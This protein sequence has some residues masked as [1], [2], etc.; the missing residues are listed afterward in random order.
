MT[1]IRI[2]GLSVFPQVGE[3]PK[4]AR[5]VGATL[6]SATVQRVICFCLGPEGTN[7]AQ[8]AR[9]WLKRMSV[10]AKSEVRLYDTPEECLTQ[11]RLITDPGVL[12][13]F[14]TCAVYSRESQFFFGNPDVLPF[15]FQE[16]MFLDE[17]QLATTGKNAAELK[18]GIIPKAWSIGS[19]PSPQHLVKSLGCNIVLVN[20]NAAAADHCQRGLV[21]ACITTESARKIYGLCTLH[22]FGSPTMIFFGGVT[23]HG[24]V[25]LKQAYFS[26]WKAR[27]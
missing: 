8:A 25:I 7:I 11:A 3:L 4:T 17:M 19:H 5:E 6:Q 26:S 10:E 16:P 14:W 1:T 22:L 15:V 20:S 21:E 23:G 13:V 2:K 9:K 18:D 24:E 27:A 12:A